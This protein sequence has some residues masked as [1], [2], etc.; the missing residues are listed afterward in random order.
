MFGHFLGPFADLGHSREVM[1][2]LGREHSDDYLV[3]LQFTCGLPNFGL[4]LL[5]GSSYCPEAVRSHRVAFSFVTCRQIMF[6]EDCS[7]WCRVS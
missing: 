5:A 2:S 3:T 6:D 4:C 7:Y 1:F